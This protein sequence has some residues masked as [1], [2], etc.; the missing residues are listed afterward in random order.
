ML[1]VKRFNGVLDK[2]SREEDVLSPNHIQARNLRFIPNTNGGS[3]N[4]IK[5]NT[6]ISNSNLPA[7][8]NECIGAFFD[9][10]KQRII[11]FNWNEYGN[12][13][14]YQYSVQTGTV[15]KIFLCNTDSATDILT[16]SR[17]YPVHSAG[18]VYRTTG[19]G[20]MLYWTDG[21]NR[22]R[23]LNLDTVS[24]LAP[25]TEDMINAAKNA[26][27]TPPALVSSGSPNG[28]AGYFSDATVNYNAVKNKFFRFAYRWVF[29][30]G[31][32]STL[33]PISDIPLPSY[34]DPNLQISVTTDN[35]IKFTVY[36]PNLEDYKAIEVM[37]QEWNGS[38]FSDFFIIESLDRDDY[39]IPVNSS[40]TYSFYNNGS[41]ITINPEESDLYFSWLP[42]KANTLEIL[43]GNVIV[44]GGLTDGYDK[45]SRE[46]VDV[47][48]TSSLVAID[49]L[50]GSIPNCSPMY[51]WNTEY[52]FGLVYFD[53]RGKTNGVV[54][55]A[56]DSNIDTTDFTVTT[57]NYAGQTNGVSITVPQISLSI[58]HLPP[59]WATSYQWVRLNLTPKF[60]QWVTMDYQ[61]DNNYLYLGIQNLTE[62]NAKTGFLPSY[63]YAEGD[64]VRIMAAVGGDNTT[65]VFSSQQD[66]PVLGVVQRLMTSPAQNGTFIKIP[67]P[68]SL[69]T[70]A[71]QAVMFIEV[72]TPKPKLPDN[73]QVFY[74]FGEKYDI[75]ESGGV[76]YHRGQLQDQTNS[77]PAT[78]AWTE[79]DVYIKRRAYYL[80]VPIQNN[81]LFSYLDMM[82]A[83]WNDYIQSSCNDN[84]RG[85]VIDE[86]AKEEYNQVLVRWGGKYQSGTNINQLNI[87]RPN[88]FDEVDR[89]K[90]DIRRFKVRDRILRVFQDRGV[91][92]YGIYA[93]FI[94]NNEGE[95]DLVTTNEII[96]TNNIQ[97]YQ[98]IFGLCGYPTNLCSSPIADYFT[99]VVTGRG[100]RLGN[101]GIT[102][103]GLLYKG[104]FYFPKLVTPYN[105][106]LTRTNGSKAKVMAFYDSFDNDFHTILQAGIGNGTT[107][108]GNHF[109][110]N[111]LRNGYFCDE[112]SYIPELALC[113]NDV[114]YSWNG[115]NLWKHDNNTTSF[116]G[117]NYAA[118]VTFVFNDNLTQ[119]KSWNAISELA[120]SIWA[121]PLIYTNQVTYGT[122]RQ[123]TNLGES[124]FTM[125]EG[126]PSAVIKRDVNS[127]GGKIN[128]NFIK[129]NWMAAKFR[130]ENA[131]NLVF[132]NEVNCRFTD[133]PRTDK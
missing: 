24:T 97:Y 105:K 70:P 8:I 127:I 43:N 6:L 92:Q 129:G 52:R 91:G 110:F 64:R 26:P 51:K 67:K 3:F 89:A 9:Q 90:G 1:A 130:K 76:R 81:A 72:Y 30:N 87:F 123:E 73:Q 10:V 36:S 74:E 102:D 106:T 11:W 32:K 101:D 75:Y 95:S 69:P 128:G 78:F 21:Y 132:L 53:D 2:D 124:E 122:Q 120:N 20:D 94:Q 14:I 83:N 111:E 19:D 59:S 68:T 104:Q 60:L 114:I 58:N 39:S 40:Y 37:G 79:G 82:D 88:D 4:P 50:L 25:F 98:G 13:G 29:K 115:G 55:F 33:S 121:C 62:M 125:L 12:N 93:R 7:G 84:G 103:L 17:D 16:F 107:T 22:P 80:S 113:A 38:E 77:Q 71:Y 61:T 35:Y 23:C 117:V 15:S 65:S 108:T 126:M 54:S 116:Y 5:G 31:E 44:Y 86:N 96:T 48:I 56:S 42:D 85:W 63:E 131:T 41:Y 66:Y 45:I 47:Q 118:D 133:S 34:I 28:V 100:I 99:D 112:Y 57:P 27:L 109:S 46:D 49:P 18:I 119:K